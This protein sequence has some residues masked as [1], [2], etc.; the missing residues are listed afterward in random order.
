MHMATYIESTAQRFKDFD[1]TKGIPYRELVGSLLWIVLCVMGP[2][3][4]RVKD[5]AKRSDSY[6]MD[7]YTDALIVLDRIISCKDHGIVFRRGGATK[8]FVPSKSRLGGGL[9]NVADDEVH[10]TGDHGVL[11]E[12]EEANLYKLDSMDDAN[13]DVE[14]IFADTNYRFTKVAYSDASFAVGLTI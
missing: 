1:L 9:E 5:L 7:D 12:L 8:D 4:L 6:V 10:S 14:K 13:L 3:L 2:E 11:N